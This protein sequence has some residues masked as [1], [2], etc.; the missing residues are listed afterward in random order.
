MLNTVSELI[1]THLE[2]RGLSAKEFAE[3]MEVSQGLVSQL[4]NGRMRAS[5]RRLETIAQI[6]D[7]NAKE[8]KELFAAVEAMRPQPYGL[9]PP[10]RDSLTEHNGSFR[11]F[12]SFQM[13][14]RREIRHQLRAGR[15]M[16]EEDFQY[17]PIRV[18]YILKE[19]KKE[20][21][22][23][24]ICWNPEVK[25]KELEATVSILRNSLEEVSKVILLFPF[26]TEAQ[27]PLKRELQSLGGYLACPM[28]LTLVLHSLIPGFGKERAFRQSEFLKELDSTTQL[29]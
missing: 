12:R 16:V 4:M 7:L 3:Q 15:N 29:F 10:V 11:T 8:R 2:K 18:D 28:T 6:L 1:R 20:W 25:A 5:P 14:L 9:A 13:S 21:I 17:G 19:S 22:A 23:L 26:F 27:L 24:M